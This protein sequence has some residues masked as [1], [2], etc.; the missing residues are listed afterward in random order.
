M[1]TKGLVKRRLSGRHREIVYIAAVPTPRV[2]EAALQKLVDEQFGG[3]LAQAA[4]AAKALATAQ[5]LNFKRVPQN[6]A[7]V[8]RLATRAIR[9]ASYSGDSEPTS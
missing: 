8:R 5:A 7:E 2:K 4:L 9:L 3:S 1:V 6:S